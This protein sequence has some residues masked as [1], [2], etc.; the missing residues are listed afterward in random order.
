MAWLFRVLG[1]LLLVVGV[2]IL[3]SP[4]SILAD[5]F[6]L[7]DAAAL[8]LSLGSILFG[9]MMAAAVISMAWLWNRPSFAAYVLAAMTLFAGLMS[10][11]L[12]QQRQ[13]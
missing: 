4:F 6:L 11:R 1:T 8:M 12:Q 9:V 13:R 3:L 2:K 7:D 5:V 10:L